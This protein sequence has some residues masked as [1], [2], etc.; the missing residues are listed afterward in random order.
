MSGW[1][2]AKKAVELSATGCRLVKSGGWRFCG[3]A[4]GAAAT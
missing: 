1:R 2:S 4:H 3:L